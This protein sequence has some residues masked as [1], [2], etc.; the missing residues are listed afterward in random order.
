MIL[1]E[2]IGLFDVFFP[3]DTMVQII[4]DRGHCSSF[5][6]R[7]CQVRDSVVYK[8][9]KNVHVKN[10]VYGIDISTRYSLSIRI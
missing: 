5:L 2:C 3:A 10:F 7:L 9:Y 4:N 6:C 8:T 1:S